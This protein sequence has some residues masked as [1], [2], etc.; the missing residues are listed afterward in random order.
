[1]SKHW[2][3]VGLGFG[4]EG[5]GTIVDTLVRREEAGAV[6]R[7]NG[8]PQAAHHVVSPTQQLHCFAQLGAGSFVNGLQTHHSRHMF[9]E[10]FALCKELEVLQKHQPEM[11][12][13]QVWIDRACL[14]V[15]PFHKLLNQM[16]EV[17]RGAGRH[18]SCGMGVGQAFMDSLKPGFPVLRVADCEAPDLLRQRLRFLWMLKKDSAAQIIEE[19]PDNEALKALYEELSAPGFC[20]LL[21]E[22]YTAF[23]RESGVQ[24]VSTSS[25]EARWR[26]EEAVVWE[27]AQGVCLDA[28]RGFWPHVTPSRT[29]PLQA[30]E[31]LTHA[32]IDVRDVRRIG[33]LRAYCSRHGAGPFVTESDWLTKRLPDWHNGTNRWQGAFRVGWFDLLLAQ[34]ALRVC[35]H[36]D[37]PRWETGIDEI[38]LTQ[39]DRLAGLA[40]VKICTGY[41]FKGPVDDAL[42]RFFLLGEGEGPEGSKRILGIRVPET[43]DRAFQMDLSRMLSWCEPIYHTL[44]GWTPCQLAQ[45]MDGQHT[46]PVEAYIETLERALRVPIT[47]ISAGV[48]ADHKRTRQSDLTSTAPANI[49]S[50]WQ[51]C[52]SLRSDGDEHL[53]VA[54]A[55]GE[56]TC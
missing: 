53:D 56:A 13:T 5:K 55:T 31:Q 2:V 40:E 11:A 34:Y 38:A 1:M 24:I 20:E 25:L 30:M 14:V 33:V 6:V 22:K 50:Q 37:T 28:E 4:D 18:G 27:G 19:H 46:G 15:T 43:P 52:V 48:R 45:W 42:E 16:Q 35:E 49:V 41:F 10:P 7:F 29:T 9:V 36:G 3:V 39:L 51:K 44:P 47:I 54:G 32:G 23:V 8:G 12:L 21:V 26:A 17:A